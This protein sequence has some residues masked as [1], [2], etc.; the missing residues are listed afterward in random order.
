[1]HFLFDFDGYI[2]PSMFENLEITDVILWNEE[3]V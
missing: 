1:M 2:L 3:E